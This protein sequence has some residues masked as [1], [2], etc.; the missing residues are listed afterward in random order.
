MSIDTGTDPYADD[1]RE[2]ADEDLL[3]ERPDL[4]PGCHTVV[5][6]GDPIPPALASLPRHARHPAPP[7][8]DPDDKPKRRSAG[9]TRPAPEQA[10]EQAPD[11]VARAW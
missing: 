4:G 3:I 11:E 9:R 10:P 5:A 6:A 2:R 1:D 7:P 8:P